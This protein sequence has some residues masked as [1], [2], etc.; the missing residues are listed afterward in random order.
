[1]RK[2]L[3]GLFAF[4]FI[5]GFAAD[6]IGWAILETVFSPKTYT[7]ALQSPEFSDAAADLMRG[8][9]TAQLGAQS[10]VGALLSSEEVDSAAKQLVTGPWLAAQMERWL[11]TLFDWLESDAPEPK[12]TL[13]F[14]E[15]KQEV[16]AIVDSLVTDKLKQLPICESGFILKALAALL[17]GNAIPI[18]LPPNFDVAGFLNSD[19]VNLRGAVTEYLASVPDE[20]DVLSLLSPEARER[21]LSALNG[22]RQARRQ[23]TTALTILGAV[24]LVLFLL[25]GI[26]RRKPRRA[27]FQWWGWTMLLAGGLALSGFGLVYAL[28][29]T[30]WTWIITSPNGALPAALSKIVETV[31]M[32]ILAPVWSRVLFRGGVAA[33]VGLFLVL[34]AFALPRGKT[35][36]RAEV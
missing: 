17:S 5:V 33:A 2:F 24:L 29:E 14:V 35:A 26:L 22:I 21:A 11:G 15:L 4:L 36:T 3:A 30:I 12:L 10:G 8:E 32:A 19:E 25:V 27:L 18:C 7:A 23:A 28:R 20:A 16:P 13:S 1:M 6:A 31:F 9:V 34:L